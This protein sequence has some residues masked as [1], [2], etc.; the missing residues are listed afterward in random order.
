MFHPDLST[1]RNDRWTGLRASVKPVDASATRPVG[2]ARQPGRDPVHVRP[3]PGPSDSRQRLSGPSSRPVTG[4]SAS[5]RQPSRSTQS[6]SGRAVA[7]LNLRGSSRRREPPDD[8]GTDRHEPC[9]LGEALH[10]RPQRRPALVVAARAEQ[11]GRDENRRPGGGVGHSEQC[12]TRRR[13]VHS[14]ERSPSRLAAGGPGVADSGCRGVQPG[15]VVPARRVMERPCPGRVAVRRSGRS[16]RAS[17]TSGRTF[18]G[19]PRLRFWGSTFPFRK[20]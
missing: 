19:R 18:G 14:E 10:P 4:S 13:R 8:L 12:G 2:G 6:A 7:P 15:L 5:S 3:S 11:A 17:A 1:G 16:R 20:S 9:G